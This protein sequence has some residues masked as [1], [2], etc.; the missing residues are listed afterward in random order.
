[1][2]G[3]RL[4]SEHI[5]QIAAGSIFSFHSCAS[6]SSLAASRSSQVSQS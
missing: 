4:S 6:Q 2:K 3:C 1:M 5:R